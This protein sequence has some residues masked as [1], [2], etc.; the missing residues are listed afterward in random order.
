MPNMPR[1]LLDPRSK[2]YAIQTVSALRRLVESEKADQIR[3]EKELATVREYR[4]WE[5]L[6]YKSEDALLEGELGKEA[7]SKL[8][9]IGVKA[10]QE[11]K[12]ISQGTRTD[13]LESTSLLCNEVRQGNAASYLARRIARERPDILERMKKGEFESVRAAAI[14]AGII[15]VPTLF[16]QTK[17]LYLK[18]SAAEKRRFKEWMTRQG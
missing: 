11:A 16:D 2:E 9:A 13:K 18:L 8:Y 1:G 14:E 15:K 6:G 3:I 4:H 7:V 5:V 17:K 12:V 10:E